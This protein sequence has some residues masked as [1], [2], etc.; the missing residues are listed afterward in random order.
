M[1][2]S[3]QVHHLENIG[4]T[5]VGDDPYQIT[6]LSLIY[7]RDVYFLNDLTLHGRRTH[8][9]HVTQAIKT[10]FRFSRV[11]R[12]F[13]KTGHSRPSGFSREMV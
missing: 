9:G 8:S 4:N 3:N 7:S 12:M 5:R 13:L 10:N 2:R 1:L 11:C 6:R